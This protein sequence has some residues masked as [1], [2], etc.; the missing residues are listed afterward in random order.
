MKHKNEIIKA[1]EDYEG[2]KFF[3]TDALLGFIETL[4]LTPV[5]EGQQ[6]PVQGEISMSNIRVYGINSNEFEGK[7]FE[8]TNNDFVHISEEQGYV[9]TLE[10]YESAFNSEEIPYDMFI[11]FIDPV[12]EEL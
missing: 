4:P 5:N 1:L 3:V 11:R 10:G 8:L 6:Q 7:I 12:K 9:W 2:D